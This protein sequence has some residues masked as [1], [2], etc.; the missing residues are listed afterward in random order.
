M[1]LFSQEWLDRMI[2]LSTEFPVREGASALI[3]YVITGGPGGDIRYYQEIKDGRFVSSS[4]TV[5]PSP[6]VTLTQSYPDSVSMMRGELDA[7]SAF[8][9]GR[10]RVSGNMGAL[11]TLLPLT[12]SP[13]YKSASTRLSTIVT[14]QSTALE[15]QGNVAQGGELGLTLIDGDVRIIAVS[16][17]GTY[18]FADEQNFRHHILYLEALGAAAY[19]HATEEL[20]ELINSGAAE[21]DLQSFFERYP[22]FLT[23]HEYSAAHP[24]LVLRKDDQLLIPDFVLEPANSMQFC[25]VLELKLPT[26]RLLVQRAGRWRLS[27][28][29]LDVSAQ[30]RAYSDYFELPSNRQRIQDAYGLSIF[31]PRMIVVIGRRKDVDPIALKRSE[32][33]LPFVTLR[34]YDDVLERVKSRTRRYRIQ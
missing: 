3:Q 6:D 18:Q 12:Q 11:M 14:E 17:D 20:E 28:A 23:G 30:L 26:S 25:D 4:P 13:E 10:I 27:A 21:R 22:D 2:A 15:E 1:E 7:N 33:E 32:S 24:H 5:H 34:T 19:R 9:Q 8:M 16:Q 29:L 31:R